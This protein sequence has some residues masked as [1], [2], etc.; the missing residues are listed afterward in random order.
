MQQMQLGNLKPDRQRPNVIVPL[1]TAIFGFLII[2][3]PA[4]AQNPV[5]KHSA[6]ESSD[7]SRLMQ[8]RDVA[9]LQYVTS[10][11]ISPDGSSIAYTVAVP[12]QPMVDEDGPAWTELY[13]ADR[14]G[15]SRP[16]ITGKVSIGS[17]Q[18]SPDGRWIY[19]LAKR[20]GDEEKLLY[21]IAVDGGESVRVV[22]HA[23][24]ISAYNL[25]PEGQTVA[26]IA[27][28]ERGSDVEALREQGFD[29]EIYEEDWLP[30]LV[31]IT[32]IN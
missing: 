21:R 19:Y 4:V 24:S 27:S 10:Q 18:W 8:P 30:K 17:V 28:K 20:E 32:S 13:V 15:N 16:F 7:R 12:R 26:F 31:W 14:Q 22:K 6:D 29:Q 11:H 25:G 5:T 1:V 2:S 9:R 3:Y 23:T